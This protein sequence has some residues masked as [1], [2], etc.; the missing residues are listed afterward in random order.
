MSSPIITVE[1]LSK[2]YR[3][4]VI[5]ATTLRDSVQRTWHRLRGRNWRHHMEEVGRADH[6]PQTKDQGPI[7][8]EPVLPD[9]LWALRDVSF[10]V[11]RGEVLGVIGKNGAGKSTLL[12]LLTRITEPT[13]G[14]AVMRGR[15]A[16]LLE[17]GTGF[18]PELTGRENVYLNGAILGMKRVE[19]ARKFDEIVE[20]SGVAKFID[21]PVKRYS[22]GMYV[23]LA[24]A[25]AAHLEPEILLIDEVLAVGDAEFQKKCLGKVKA[26]AEEGRTV[27]LVSHNMSSVRTFADRA[28]LLRD[29]GIAL[30]GETSMVIQEYLDRNLLHSRIAHREEIAERVEGAPNSGNPTVVLHEIGISDGH[31][32]RKEMFDSTDFIVVTVAYQCLLPVYGLHIVVDIVNEDSIPLLT[33]QN[34]DDPVCAQMGRHAP[35]MYTAS[36]TFPPDTFGGRSLYVSVQLVNPKTEHLVVNKIL[37]LN[38]RFLGYNDVEYGKRAGIWF[39]PQLTWSVDNLD[40]NES[41]SEKD[42]DVCRLDG[43]RCVV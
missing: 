19:I 38:V 15:V 10:E 1:N 9:E 35:G 29:G 17:V 5:G 39:R 3:L 43:G 16:G 21:T 33:T 37:P 4:G 40:S 2:R 27:L 32:E 31:G 36:C 28:I 6:N 41:A 30:D 14:R 13:S 18:H 22:S 11:K 12:K 7:G 8:Q 26:V 24:F 34:L 20:F 25:V 42:G 23:R